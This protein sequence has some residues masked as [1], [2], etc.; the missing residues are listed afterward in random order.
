MSR[1][2]RLNRT[3]DLTQSEKDLLKKL[4]VPQNSVNDFASMINK[5]IHGNTFQLIEKI[6]N[7]SI[8]LLILDPPYNLSKKFGSNSFKAKDEKAYSEWFSSWFN[9][10]LNKLKKSA[11]VYICCDWKTS[12]IIYDLIKSNLKVRNRITWERE[13]GRG[14]IKNW[15][16]CHEDIWFATVSNHYTFN[17]R[18]VKLKRKVLAPYRDNGNAKDWVEEENN[19]FRVTFPS[20]LWNDI[21]VPFWSMP[22]NTSHPTQK[23]E[24]LIAKLI[25]ASSNEGDLILDPF[26][27]SG[28][29]AAVSKKLNRNFIGIEEQLEYCCLAQKRLI[30]AEKNKTI[31]GYDGKNFWERNS[32]RYYK[33]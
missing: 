15:K 14:A 23:P 8:D 3:M 22:E 4:V 7:N 27:G 12:T 13:K 11:S 24:K 16:N 5:I 20:N 9:I 2:A 32:L 25:L 29:T 31:Q 17:S 33:S 10:L 28:T 1:K 26:L 19:K 30:E 21:T 18:D 6:A